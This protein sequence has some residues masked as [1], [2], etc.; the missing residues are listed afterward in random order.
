MKQGRIFYQGRVDNIVN[1]FQGLG[2]LCPENYNPSDFV[3]NLCQTE[4]KE[5]V[6]AVIPVEF[7]AD[8]SGTAPGQGI[9]MKHE[10]NRLKK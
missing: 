3:M 6:F 1:H 5:D 4:T 2:H 10:Y 9:P 8:S 7:Q